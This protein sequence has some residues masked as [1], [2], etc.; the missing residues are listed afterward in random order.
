MELPPDELARRDA[1][2]VHWQDQPIRARWNLSDLVSSDSHIFNGQFECTLRVGT[3]AADRRIFAEMFLRESPSA[4]RAQVIAFLEPTL[5]QAIK[6]M[7]AARNADE[8]L[9]SP[10]AESIAPLQKALAAAGFACGVEILPPF[11]L[12]LSSQS[13]EQLQKRSQASARHLHDL[14]HA[15]ELL[16]EFQS[17]QEATPDLPAG[18]LLDK[19]SPPDR[20][21]ALQSLL[22]ASAEESQPKLLWGVAGSFLLKIDPRQ[23]LPSI[24]S[25]ELQNEFGPF[26]SIQLIHSGEKMIQL[27]GAQRGIVWIE[28]GDLKTMIGYRAPD[29]E[30]VLGFNSVVNDGENLWA[31]HGEL[32]LLQWKT[33]EP[34]TAPAVFAETDARHLQLLEKSR[35]LYASGNGWIVRNAGGE[36]TMF[37][38][39]SSSPIVGIVARLRTLIAVHEDGV[40]DVIDRD[41]GRPIESFSRSGSYNAVG[42]MPWMGDVR[43][44]LATEAG[45]MDC[46]GIDDPL[47]TQFLSPYRGLRMVSA[48]TDLV[49]AVSPDRQRIIIWKS[50]DDQRPV[51]EIAVT[52]LVKHRVTDVCFET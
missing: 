25:I 4:M 17:M 9:A 36:V 44:L 7:I 35:V 28:N 8:C 29:S 46:V 39:E 49:A 13:F 14:K 10:K 1:N 19:I 2:Q 47:V 33:K 21:L 45:P 52:R 5:K 15:R 20:G 50:W 24:E 16:S 3:H 41:T 40:F 26:R 51:G 32:G 42:A 6:E 38:G 18:K 23:T 34:G 48:T 22:L 11:E 30:S 43:L 12:Q 27:L 37:T 31:T